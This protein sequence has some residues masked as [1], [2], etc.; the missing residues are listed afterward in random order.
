M[1]PSYG[2]SFI[3]VQYT[4]LLKQ[5]HQH[6][7]SESGGTNNVVG[8]GI[9][10]LGNNNLGVLDRSMG[11]DHSA[12]NIG[13]EGVKGSSGGGS[14]GALGADSRGDSG[15]DGG[16]VNGASSIDGGDG[17]VGHVD[18]DNVLVSGSDSSAVGVGSS[19]G[20][21]SKRGGNRELH[22]CGCVVMIDCI[23]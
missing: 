11:G 6:G 2:E 21:N 14:L 1:Y 3:I 15:P 19:E 12:V 7:D 9:G 16:V 13:L 20:S 10:L 22:C 4:T 5:S 18:G 17:A 23:E 8:S